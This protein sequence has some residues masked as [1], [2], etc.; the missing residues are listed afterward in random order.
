MH[1]DDKYLSEEKK[2]DLIE[3]FYFILIFANTNKGQIK[4]TKL[5]QKSNDSKFIMQ[6]NL[7]SI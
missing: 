4:K 1:E 2:I 7:Y 6:N 3:Y 5:K